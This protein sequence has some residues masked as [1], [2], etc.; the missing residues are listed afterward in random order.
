MTRQISFGCMLIVLILMPA[1]FISA[2]KIDDP[3]KS[4]DN[5]P[6][7]PPPPEIGA[8]AENVDVDIR[9]MR[10]CVELFRHGLQLGEKQGI[11]AGLKDKLRMSE[12]RGDGDKDVATENEI[13]RLNLEIKKVATRFNIAFRSAD[14]PDSGRAEFEQSIKALQ[15]HETKKSQDFENLKLKI[16]L[17][18]DENQQLREQLKKRLPNN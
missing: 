13:E 2:Q 6:A 17:L 12:S 3:F 11:R 18:E 1:P 9:T 8:S 7:F 14:F 5:T 10:R 15:L 16:Q 4:K